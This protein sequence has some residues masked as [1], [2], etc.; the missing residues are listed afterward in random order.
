LDLRVTP[1]RRLVN[2]KKYWTN[3]ALNARLTWRCK[4]DDGYAAGREVLLVPQVGVGC[5]QRLEPFFLGGVQQL[6]ICQ[7]R[8][9]ALVGGDDF[10][11]RQHA[12]Q[13]F[14]RALIE[15]YAHLGRGERAAGG[16][17]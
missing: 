1:W 17:I 11:L 4:H 5:D 8:P 10:M 15:Q 12:T 9:T 3:G 7:L 13:W 6:A 14:G 16:V 2:S